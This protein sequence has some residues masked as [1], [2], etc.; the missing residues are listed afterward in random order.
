MATWELIATAELWRQELHTQQW[1]RATV[2]KADALCRTPPWG[3]SRISLTFGRSTQE[4]GQREW[5]ATAGREQ[6]KVTRQALNR[7]KSGAEF[8]KN[9]KRMHCQDL[10]YPGITLHFHA[11]HGNCNNDMTST[12]KRNHLILLSSFSQQAA[13]GGNTMTNRVFR[14]GTLVPCEDE[15]HLH[16]SSDN[17]NGTISEWMEACSSTQ[18]GQQS[19]PHWARGTHSDTDW[20]TRCPLAFAEAC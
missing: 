4:G 3:A 19:D 14:E 15:C 13:V 5:N 17:L 20:K 16:S 11:W 1:I 18:L 6:R 8:G 9:V 2:F 12:R 7:G 10:S